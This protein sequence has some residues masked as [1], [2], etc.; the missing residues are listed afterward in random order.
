M[1]SSL[2]LIC[3]AALSLSNGVN[4][5]FVPAAGSLVGG[6]SSASRASH[7]ISMSSIAHGARCSCAS[8]AGVHG[9]SCTCPSCS[10]TGVSRR[11]CSAGCRCAGCSVRMKAHRDG[12]DTTSPGGHRAS[13]ECPDCGVLK[14]LSRSRRGASSVTV[15]SM[16][17]GE[18]DR[19]LRQRLV[20]EPESVQFEDTMAAIAE[21]FDYV[22]KR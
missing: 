4:G 16:G 9:R 22:P 17:G 2:V 13:C 3:A 7:S 15:M 5:F 14:S 19:A 8:C 20:D 1:K 12:E 6:A 10:S 11:S 18:G 21:G